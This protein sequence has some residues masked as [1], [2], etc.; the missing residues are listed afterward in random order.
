MITTN[1]E[2]V[3]KIFEDSAKEISNKINKGYYY[4]ES[5][6]CGIKRRLNTGSP[7]SA[8]YINNN[9]NNQDGKRKCCF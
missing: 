2:N 4:L 5:D 6:V 9:N 7:G 3:D 1:G 8:V